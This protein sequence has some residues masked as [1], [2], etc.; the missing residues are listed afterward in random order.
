[1]VI[2][3]P[4]P[5]APFLDTAKSL[6]CIHCGLCLSS[7]PTY[8]ETGNENDSPRGRIYLMRALQDGRLPAAGTAQRHIDLCLG[9]R[10]CEAVC[11]SGVH[12]GELLEA[13]RDHLERTTRRPW[14]DR[15]LRR[16]AIERVLPFP[17]RLRWALKPA[18]WIKRLGLAES[19]PERAR[20]A[21]ELLPSDPESEPVP[22]FSP[23]ATPPRARVGFVSGCV[24]S[25]LFGETHRSSLRLLNAA[26]CDVLTPPTQGCC[27]A[28]YA[29]AGQLEEARACA[30]RNIAA[31]EPCEFDA[32]ITN[33]AGCGSTLK[34]YGLLLENDPD[35]ADRARTFSARVK[36]LSEWLVATGADVAFNVTGADA[37]LVTF[38]DACH[39]AHAQ[40]VTRAP[41]EL[42]RRVAG[43][44]WVE[45]PESDVCCGSA[46]SYN[47]TEPEMAARLQRRK[48]ANIL[49][50]GATTVVTTNPGCMLQIQAGLKKA[51]AAAVRV[52]HLADFLAQHLSEP[53]T[54]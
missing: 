39:L 1:M 3:P 12:Y 26:G 9:C 40:R 6:A 15:L 29:H 27:G 17:D 38:H 52:V 30:R 23:A 33:A 34:E 16:V 32:I 19:L 18:R 28:L 11:P 14:L 42:A 47:L 49:K 51:G 46:G 22:E 37:G 5:P 20:E 25:V 41:R 44:R 21:L 35:F 7:C 13:T 2:S 36:D 45:L 48:I 54:G 8:L 31:F 53:P 10:A 24:M 50:T 4:S 43:Q